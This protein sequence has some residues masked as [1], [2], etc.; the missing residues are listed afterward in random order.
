MNTTALILFAIS[1][2]AVIIFLTIRISFYWK[3]FAG[4]FLLCLIMN[5]SVCGVYYVSPRFQNRIACML[6][7]PVFIILIQKDLRANIV[8]AIRGI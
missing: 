5:A 7:L 6:L 4:F 1:L 8:Q 2:F 3:F